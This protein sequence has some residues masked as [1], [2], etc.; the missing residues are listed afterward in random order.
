MIGPEN[1]TGTVGDSADEVHPDGPPAPYWHDATR[2]PALARVA[3]AA[4][5]GVTDPHEAGL[6][7][8]KLAAQADPHVDRPAATV[9][10]NTFMY[11]IEVAPVHVQ[12]D[13]KLEP[14]DG[15][16]LF[17]PALREAED[18]LR[19]LWLGL[20]DEVK[21]P[22]ARARCWDIVFT[23]RLMR[24]RR[25][26]AEQA[27]RAYLDAAATTL[28][29]QRKADGLVRAWTMAR[30]VGLADLTDEITTAMIAIAEEAVAR[31][32]DPYAAIGVLGA[33]IAP[34][35]RGAPRT[36]APA[37]DDLLDR[38]LTTYPQ[39]HIIKDLAVLVRRSAGSGTE[40][41][42]QASRYEVRAMLAE[43]GAATD[44]M[45]IRI[46]LN[47]A[48]AAARRLG[49]TDMERAAVAR[50]Q[51][52]P[53]LTWDSAA[54]AITI[55]AAFFDH[56]LPGF[57]ASASWR[58]ALAIWLHTGPPSGGRHVN[59]A[60][61]RQ[62]LRTS[63][64]YRLATTVLF[65]DGDLPART[66]SSGDDIFNRELVRAE[67]RYMDMSGRFL[68][69]ALHQIRQRFGIPSQDDLEAFLLG[70]GAAAGLATAV[71]TA[72]QLYWV[73]EYDASCHLVVPK[74]EAAVRALLLELNE[75]LYRAAVGDG[76]GQFPG[77]GSLLPLLVDN[78]F[79]PDW[80][81]FL[82]TFLLNDG[83][84]VR[85][86]VAHGFADGVGPVEA[87]LALRA[88]ALLILITTEDAT[89]RDAAAV[90]AALAT[91]QGTMAPRSWR[92][93]LVASFLAAR[94]ELRSSG[95]A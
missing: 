32:E 9:L 65:R 81:R 90:R 36:A 1:T 70:F 80:E 56:Y 83:L 87:A 62:G 47:E 92:Q 34:P 61:A 51:A 11:T 72:L 24:N 58:H 26:A 20:A 33:L 31:R 3:D 4:C 28:S 66:L 95:T 85:N 25:D 19:R 67:T 55:P 44:P 38:A 16:S 86:L 77:L 93:R 75:P 27:A 71:A 39:I 46:L 84:N 89:E 68:A 5:E 82:R 91:P 14:L 15:T 76:V 63:V 37:I 73:G 12:P 18:D 45:I 41:A 7:V 6:R 52:A 88:G 43:A 59:E 21:H 54:Y 79:D 29:R 53:P 10:R 49:L 40:R 74:I 17:P 50:L 94:R 69:R 2:V 30:L 35:P 57:S 64:V 22:V 23:L 60:T 78:D 13:A 42:E 48:A 8:E